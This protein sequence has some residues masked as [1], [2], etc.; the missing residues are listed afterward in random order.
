MKVPKWYREV[1]KDMLHCGRCGL[2]KTRN[3]VVGMRGGPANIMFIG[4]APGREEDQQGIPFVGA[5]GRNFE[6]YCSEAGIKAPTVTN[7]V[8]CRPS[9]NRFPFDSEIEACSEWLDLQLTFVAPRIV[10]LMGKAAII[11]FYPWLA[12]QPIMHL[13]GRVHP[14]PDYSEMEFIITY[15][16][17]APL[18]NKM[19]EDLIK[20]DFKFAAAQLEAI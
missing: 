14:H 17:G 6:M 1:E 18:Y 20:T 5:A 12:R 15:H 4:E 8:K 11:R 19:Y 13:R 16:P 3:K 2:A 10:V 9:G 7:V